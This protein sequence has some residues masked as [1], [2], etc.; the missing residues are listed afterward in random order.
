[1]ELYPW[2]VIGHGFFVILALGAPGVSAFTAFRVKA[3]ADR[4]E[5]RTLLDLSAMSLTVAGVGPSS[6]I[7]FGVCAAR[8]VSGLLIA[9][10]FG[11]WA[12]IAGGHFARL[13]PWVAIGVVIVITGAMTPLAAG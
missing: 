7:P 12:A 1:M 2:I 4:A 6:A 8:A 10:L 11:I 3:S 13:W 9:I 5:L